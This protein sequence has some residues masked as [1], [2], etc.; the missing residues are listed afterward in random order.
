MKPKDLRA[1]DLSDAIGRASDFAS[2]AIK[3]NASPEDT[4]RLDLSPS[5]YLTSDGT[6]EG[7]PLTVAELIGR[8]EKV[9]TPGRKPS[10][11]DGSTS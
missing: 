11:T 1:S 3:L 5:D 4:F 2:V 6:D 8:G 9:A 10:E 7:T